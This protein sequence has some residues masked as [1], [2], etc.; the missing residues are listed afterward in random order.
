M[1]A[2]CMERMGL[3]P[4]FYI[5]G[6]SPDLNA[7][8]RLAGNAAIV[9]LD[10]S[11]G[12]MFNVDSDCLVITNLELDHVDHYSTHEKLIETMRLYI[13]QKVRKTVALNN[14]CP[15]VGPLADFAG[16]CGKRV[17]T[18]G[19]GKNS[20]DIKA[21][22]VSSSHEGTVFEVYCRGMN[23]ISARLSVPGLCNVYNALGCLAALRAANIDIALAA[24]CLQTV[25][26]PD[27]RFSLRA[28]VG[29]VKF[30]DDYAHH[31]TEVRAVLQAAKQTGARVIAVF[32]PH[33]HTRFT[34]FWKEFAAAFDDADTAVI[35]DI[36]SA[37]ER[38]GVSD[39]AIE[40]FLNYVG[41]AASHIVYV[42]RNELRKRI[43][44]LLKS[45]DAV[46]AIGA[47][48]ITFALSE[49]IEEFKKTEGEN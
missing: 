48:D 26:L 49:I 19:L 25:R 36:Y 7:N 12:S 40:D 11:D 15:F 37:G 34:R 30:Y 17:I 45:K 8:A 16:K 29:G 39:A 32:Q 10:E 27:R 43:P 4:T 33:R 3:N 41:C 24:Q 18:F 13:Q 44:P 1:A 47:G 14:D 23:K 6:V 42:P 22:V 46:V 31:P 21:E 9:E 38:P 28:Q 20:A 35:T 5:G 2:V